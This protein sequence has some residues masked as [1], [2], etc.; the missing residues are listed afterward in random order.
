[1]NTQFFSKKFLNVFLAMGIILISVVLVI[2]KQL[3]SPPLVGL[4]QEASTT[5]PIL[6]PISSNLFPYLEV[7]GG[8]DWSYSG[9]CINMRSGPGIEYPVVLRLRN[10]IVLK[11]AGTISGKDGKQWYKVEQDAELR[12]PDRV[13]SEWYVLADAVT[14]L[15]NDGDH[16]LSKGNVSTTTKRIVVRLS[17]EM[18]YAYDGDTL[19][20]QEPISTGLNLTPTSIG[21]FTV[22]A[23]TPSRYMQGPIVGFSD[24]AYDLPGVPWNLYFTTGGEVIHGAYWHNSFGRPW[25]HGCVNLSPDSAKKLYLWA[26]IGMKVSVEP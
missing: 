12:Y 7:T 2:L 25:S 6:V 24:Q 16:R 9:T 20:M 1:M 13:K 14:L 4:T 22:Y 19:F 17:E 18:L 26:D 23:M 3:P 15:H 10:G 21:N 8:C 5:P 11:V